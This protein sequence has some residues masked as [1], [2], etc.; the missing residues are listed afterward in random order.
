M[1][2]AET[3]PKQPMVNNAMPIMASTREKPDRF[4]IQEYVKIWLPP[5]YVHRKIFEKLANRIAFGDPNG[6]MAM[7]FYQTESSFFRRIAR[8][9]NV[10]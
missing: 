6:Q 5:P 1:T 10:S 8:R 2:D 9:K 7:Y 3:M 4:L